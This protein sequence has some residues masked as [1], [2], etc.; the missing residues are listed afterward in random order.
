[1][2]APSAERLR[3][4]VVARGARLLGFEVLLEREDDEHR[5]ALHA[6]EDGRERHLGRG[7][8]RGGPRRDGAGRDEER[9]AEQEG[10]EAG[11]KILARRPAHEPS[12]PLFSSRAKPTATK[13]R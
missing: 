5:V 10:P 7:G 3:R 9:E 4:R 12:F 2:H 1:R 6:V 8:A 13:R 11:P